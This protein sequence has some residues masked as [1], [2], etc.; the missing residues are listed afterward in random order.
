MPKIRII[1]C[2]FVDDTSFNELDNLHDLERGSALHQNVNVVLDDPPYITCSVRSQIS[3]AHCVF[4]KDNF[5]DA[6]E[7]MR[8]AV[9]RGAQGHIFCSYL[10]FSHWS[11]S[12]LWVKK[13]VEDAE[14]DPQGLEERLPHI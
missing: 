2:C 4:C 5:E 10:M 12:N 11:K 6:V 7:L 1:E 3:S 9:A 14:T 13:M 8:K